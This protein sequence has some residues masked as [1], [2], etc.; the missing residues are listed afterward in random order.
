MYWK[1]LYD[2]KC[3]LCRKFI[4]FVKKFNNGEIQC[5]SLYEYE[6]NNKEFT[7]QELLIDI[8]M[9]GEHGEVLIGLDAINKIIS[10]IPQI[11]KFSWLLN[12][13]IVRQNNKVIYKTIKKYRNCIMCKK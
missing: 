7:L 9:I 5:I 4:K 6:K 3:S 12:T 2:E 13:K 10:F 8:H 11:E 1:L